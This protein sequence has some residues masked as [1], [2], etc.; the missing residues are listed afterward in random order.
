LHYFNRSQDYTGHSNK[1]YTYLRHAEN[2]N[3]LIVLNF[4]HDNSETV[5]IK[6]PE[7]ALNKLGLPGGKIKLTS[8]TNSLVVEEGRD[9]VMDIS[10]SESLTFELPPNGYQ[11][12]NLEALD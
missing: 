5:N 4:D 1:V 6:L 9:A 7:D 2:D 12:F 8:I 3:L 11:I 10:S